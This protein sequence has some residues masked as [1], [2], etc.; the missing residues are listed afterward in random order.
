MKITV[1]TICY[2]SENTIRKTIESVLNQTYNELEYIIQDGKSVDSTCEIIERYTRDER[3]RFYS[4]PDKGIY[5][6]MNRALDRASGNYIIYMN[7]GDVFYN[8]YVIEKMIN[9][10]VSDIVYGSTLRHMIHQDV[11]EQYKGK[12]HL[13]RLLLMGR[14]PCHQ[15]IFV[16]T[17]LMRK[18]RFDE[19]Y[20]ICADYDFIVRAYSS[21]ILFK[22]ENMIVSEVD[23]VNGVSS[24][25]ENLSNMRQQDDKALKKSLPT[26]YYITIIPK[27]IY[28]VLKKIEQNMVA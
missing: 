25:P 17:E 8:E 15:S 4:E 26:L 14:M 5:D 13:I 27:L 22:Y 3:V 28:R 10:L 16:K 6:A 20:S 12:Y 21:N 19:T 24:Q 11:V 1:V 9:Y 7:S 2:N 23:N 18:F